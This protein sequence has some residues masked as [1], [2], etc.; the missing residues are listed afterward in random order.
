VI[1]GFLADAG[2]WLVQKGKDVINGLWD[3]LK[4]FWNNE[5]SGWLNIG[6]KISAAV[7]DLSHVLEAAGEAVIN[8]LWGGMK[9]VWHDV[10]GWL[11]NLNP[12][13]WFNDINLQKGHA[14]VNL[15]PTG[16]TVM[17]GLQAGMEQGWSD[18]TRWLSTLNPS[19]S[20]AAGSGLAESVSSAA[21]SHGDVVDGLARIER[22][23]ARMPKDY[24][25][26]AR[27]A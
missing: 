24:Q 14:A 23:L 9:A 20:L 6:S 2:T 12:A 17:Q 26:A 27:T 3:G 10:T 18:T 21:L 22:T 7:G 16:R 8:G 13:N 19:A 5:V 1:L 15:L 25:L 11:S 4:T